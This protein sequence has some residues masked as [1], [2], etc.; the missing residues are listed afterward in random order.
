MKWYVYWIFKRYPFTEFVMK[1]VF[2]IILFSKVNV[3]KNPIWNEIMC[4]DPSR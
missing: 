2:V 4:T 1:F 3:F